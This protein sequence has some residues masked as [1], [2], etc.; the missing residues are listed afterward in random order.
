MDVANPAYKIADLCDAATD[1]DA[2]RIRLILERQPDLVNVMV[3]ENNEHRAI[4]Y[5]VMNGHE[6]V[7]RLLV[8]RGAKFDA[9]IYPHREATGALTIAQERGLD[10]IAEIIRDEDEKQ[11]LAACENIEISPENDALFEAVADKDVYEALRLIDA[12][13]ELLNACHRNGGSVLYAAACGGLYNLVHTLLARGAD[14]RHLTPAGASPLDGAVQHARPRVLPLNEGCLIA[15][16]LLLQAG[17]DISLETAVA[18]G[19]MPHVRKMAVDRPERFV[20]D[21]VMRL[22]LLQRAV[23]ADNVEMVQLLLELGCHPDDEHE[24][25]EYESRPKSGGEPLTRAAGS[26]QCEIAQIL[27][28]AGADPNKGPYASGNPVGQAYN[29]RDSRMKGLLLRYGGI[30]E[31]TFAGLEGET[32]VAAVCLHKDRDLAESL[33]WAAGCGGD[34]DLA[35]LCLRHLNWESNDDRWMRLLEQPIRLWRLHPHRNFKDIDRTVY[36][37]IF[38]MI[39]EHGASPDVVDRFG[40]RLAHHLAATGTVWGRHI[41][42]LESDRI[43]F[44][45]ILIDHGADLDLLDD[46][47]ESTPLG[48]AARWDRYE[49]AELYLENGADPHLAGSDWSKPLAWAE[50]RGNKRVAGLIRRYV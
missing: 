26:G 44:G 24:L 47:L 37:K 36:P 7:V 46:L 23:E 13:P 29:N 48:W 20:N 27:L 10:S 25:G 38:R 14:F 33:L 11:Q 2:S 31:A 21:G 8:Q 28:E 32:A 22:G 5:A 43:A 15:A 49:L 9:G 18:L 19:D 34:I 42:M 6:E 12:Q 17:C 4:H 35:G 16:G 41:V 40:Y 30:L 3:A 1:G 45:R 39:L 50:K